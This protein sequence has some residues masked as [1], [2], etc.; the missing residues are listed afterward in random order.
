MS[1]SFSA[2]EKWERDEIDRQLASLARD[3]RRLEGA[4][5]KVE[6]RLWE[7]ESRDGMR[8]H[9]R[10]TVLFWAIPAVFVAFEIVMIT[11]KVSAS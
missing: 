6:Q 8:L 3:Q 7:F 11:L 9:L 1:L 5:R 2:V 10:D 4:N